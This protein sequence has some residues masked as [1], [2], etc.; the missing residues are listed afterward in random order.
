M[1]SDARPSPFFRT[2]MAS[3]QRD[4]HPLA[5]ADVGLLLVELNDA[6]HGAHVVELQRLEQDRAAVR[7]PRRNARHLAGPAPSG[8]GVVLESRTLADV[9]TLYILLLHLGPGDPR[10]L[11]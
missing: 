2:L 4:A 9:D 3:L 5:D 11:G 8:S 1:R 7:V 10:R 6:L